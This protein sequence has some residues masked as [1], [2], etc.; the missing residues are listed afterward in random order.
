M[1]YREEFVLDLTHESLS[2]S[3]ERYQIDQLNSDYCS[4][5]IITV[6]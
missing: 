1:V 3:S 2:K 6:K 5:N 4:Q